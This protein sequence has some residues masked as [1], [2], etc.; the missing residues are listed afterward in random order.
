MPYIKYLNTLL[1]DRIGLCTELARVRTAYNEAVAAGDSDMV[2]VY[3]TRIAF[4]LNWCDKA[5]IKVGKGI[6]PR[7]R[8]AEYRNNNQPTQE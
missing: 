6:D 3:H 2:N 4:V 7:P 1:S 8:A 5:G